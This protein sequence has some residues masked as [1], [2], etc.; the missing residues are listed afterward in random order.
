MLAHQH[1][2]IPVQQKAKRSRALALLIN[3]EPLALLNGLD[4]DEADK[5]TRLRELVDAN[6]DWLFQFLEGASNGALDALVRKRITDQSH[7]VEISKLFDKVG[8]NK[9]KNRLLELM[10]PG[11]SF[12]PDI[13]ENVH[14]PRGVHRHYPPGSLEDLDEFVELGAINWIDWFLRQHARRQQVRA[15]RRVRECAIRFGQLEVLKWALTNGCPSPFV[16]GCSQAAARGQLE[17]LKWMRA[18]ECPWDE[19]TCFSAAWF[20][21][22]DVLNGMCLFES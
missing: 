21:H 15:L 18:N 19:S 6:E 5:P 20:G 7:L 16:D 17:I 4:D 12:D 22:L 10:I 9:H 11:N 13:D 3:M 14:L 2:P 1:E 8:V